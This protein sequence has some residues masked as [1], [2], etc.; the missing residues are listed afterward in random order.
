MSYEELFDQELAVVN[1]GVDTFQETLEAVGTPVI[2]VDWK[3]PEVDEDLNRRLSR[4]HRE[5]DRI[6]EANKE[7]LDRMTAAQPIW[8]DVKP[9]GEA[10][11]GVEGNMIL[12]A[13]PPVTWDRMS[14]PQRGAV[15]GAAMYEGWADT[16]EEARAMAAEEIT[17]EPCHEH[18]AVGPMSGVMSPSMPVAVVENQEHGNVA[19]S[20]LNE[21][22][23]KVLRFGAYDDEVLERLQWMEDELA[24][25]LQEVVD[26]LGGINLKQLTAEALQMGDECH[27]RNN[28]ATSLLARKVS[29]ALVEGEE[30]VEQRAEVAAFLEDN[31][32]FYLNLSMAA[33]KAM[34]DA[35]AD[36]PWCT[37]LTAMTRNG[38]DFAIR[39]SGL[40]GEWF[41]T[42]APR[43][44]GLYFSEYSKDDA[45][46]DMGDSSIS[47]TAGIGGF[48]M[49]SSP[50]ITQFVG[51]SP[52][53]ALRYTQT[54]YEITVGK[55]PNFTIPALDF[56]GTPTG[57]DLLQVLDTGVDPIINTGIAHKEPGVG[58]IGAG[59]THAPRPCFNEAATAFCD[60]YLDGADDAEG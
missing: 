13:G 43:V 60:Q 36:I 31:D 1:V 27:N 5:G 7:A 32:H 30:P 52:S 51:G 37:V 45:A 3:P 12:H 14:G 34:T 17:F 55:N 20:N 8:I 19:Y 47:E 21:G 24:P 16:P 40:E 26:R 53:D 46:R 9:A 15:I 33:S 11:P 58:Q 39:V 35:A 23:G 59:V 25:V 50:A 42:E 29:E 28:A 4:L 49:A 2:S 41:V 6:R 48:A 44:D 56:K 18:Q 54:M 38:T 57:I 22:L 10:L